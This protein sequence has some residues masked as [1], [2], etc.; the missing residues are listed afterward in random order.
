[1]S[2]FAAIDNPSMTLVGFGIPFVHH[3]IVV[4]LSYISLEYGET[5]RSGAVHQGSGKS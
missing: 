5:W 3:S 2:P 1:M 4:V